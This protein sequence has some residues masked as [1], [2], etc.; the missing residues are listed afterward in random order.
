MLMWAL[1]WCFCDAEQRRAVLHVLRCTRAYR[2]DRRRFVV[3]YS[4]LVGVG[5]AKIAIPVVSPALMPA[6]HR[7]AEPIRNA[8]T[9]HRRALAV[10]LRDCRARG[11]SRR[12]IRFTLLSVPRI[13]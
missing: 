2:R 9:Q 5:P 10:A 8:A 11:V 4:R 6:Y 3:L 1:V 7:T 13:R 12:L